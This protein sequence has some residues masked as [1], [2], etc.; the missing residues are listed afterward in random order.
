MNVLASTEKNRALKTERLSLW[1]FC[2]GNLE[3]G[4]LYLGPRR[5]CYVRL[6]KWASVSKGAPFWRTWGDAAFLGPS[7][8]R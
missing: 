2:E 8:E 3:G 4:L 5:I 7:R 1:E 6:W